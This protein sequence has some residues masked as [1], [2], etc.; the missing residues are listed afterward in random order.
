MKMHP[1]G[2]HQAL[3][4]RA[5]AETYGPILEIGGGWYST[6]LVSAISVSQRRMAL[7]VETG[8]FV[9]D[10]L[11]PLSTERHKILLMEG[12]EF[13]DIGKFQ[14]A[15]GLYVRD[16]IARQ[17]AYL[18]TLP[19]IHWSVVFVDQAPGFLRVPAIQYFSNRADFIITHDTEHVDHYHFEPILSSFQSRFDFILHKPQSVVVSNTKD[20]SMFNHL[21]AG[22]KAGR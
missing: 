20:C 22:S 12:F 17:E 1:F 21:N 10:I 19:D 5:M 7:T 8:S 15:P 11:K 4:V 2:T 6:P 16:Y 9:H 13:T 18:A 3:L 14:A